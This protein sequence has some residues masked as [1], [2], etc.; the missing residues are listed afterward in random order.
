M[1]IE[2]D[3]NAESTFNVV[4]CNDDRTTME[5][6]VQVLMSVFD[7]SEEDAKRITLDV[8]NSGQANAET[9][10]SLSMA[11][12]KV[13]AIG[14]MATAAGF[15][16][17]AKITNEKGESVARGKGKAPPGWILHGRSPEDY[18]VVLDK[19]VFHSGTQS[20]F[21]K[22]LSEEPTGFCTLMQNFSARQY[23]GNRLRMSIWIKTA[24][25]KGRV[26][27]WMRIDGGKRSRSIRFD[28]CCERPIQGTNDWKEY[29]CVLDIPP[30][31]TGIAFG[32]IFD[33][34]GMV[35]I[36]DVSFETVDMDVP[37][38]DCAC[39]SSK[40]TPPRNLSFEEN[41]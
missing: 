37:A 24:D 19:E 9:Y 5:F 17:K 8:H 23:L 4:L 22:N 15:P 30:E 2:S 10:S 11:K 27:P 3:D 34:V 20:A 33:G 7:K 16:L 12:S 18:E 1:T 21:F 39:F 13:Y 25:V 28:N 26:Q 40:T 38:T 31:S 36:D 6:V 14:L 29:Q 32:V 35:W 41:E